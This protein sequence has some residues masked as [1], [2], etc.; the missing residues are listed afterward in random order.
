MTRLTDDDRRY[1]EISEKAFQKQVLGLASLLGWHTL[2][3]SIGAK[4]S[5][6]RK[7]VARY[8]T[9]VQGSLGK[10]WPD[11]VLVHERTGRLIFAELKSEVGKLSPEQV[12]VLDILRQTALEVYVWRPRDIDEIARILA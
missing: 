7:T 8:I 1:R 2:H 6:D 11:L 12:D 10:G 5:G 9:P 4:M 3:I